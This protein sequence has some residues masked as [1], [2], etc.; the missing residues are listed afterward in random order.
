MRV[1]VGEAVLLETGDGEAVF[2]AV[3][4]GVYAGVFVL[5]YVG[6][7]VRVRV[8]VGTSGVVVYVGVFVGDVAGRSSLMLST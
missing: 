1:A 3:S 5:E 4:V 8:D 6:V 7:L 2:D